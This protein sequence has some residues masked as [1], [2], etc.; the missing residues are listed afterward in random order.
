MK[1]L[2]TRLTPA[3]RDRYGTDFKIVAVNEGNEP[4]GFKILIELEKESDYPEAETLPTFE[5]T[6]DDLELIESII[7]KKI[8]MHYEKFKESESLLDLPAEETEHQPYCKYCG[9]KLAEDQTICHVC[10]KMV[11]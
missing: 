11:I 6:N 8:N 10:G 3:V 2:A 1:F 7:N 4:L 9:S 5:R